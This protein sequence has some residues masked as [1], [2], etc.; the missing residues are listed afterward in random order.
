MEKIARTEN[1]DIFTRHI[2]RCGSN[3]HLGRK[4]SHDREARKQNV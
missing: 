4:R 1:R 3:P 2:P